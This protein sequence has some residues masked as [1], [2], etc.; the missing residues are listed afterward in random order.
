ME[1]WHGKLC[2]RD[3]NIDQQRQTAL[4]SMVPGSAANHRMQ[5]TRAPRFRLTESFVRPFWFLSESSLD[6]ARG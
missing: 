3:A 5:P 4:V 2:K 1:L 6:A